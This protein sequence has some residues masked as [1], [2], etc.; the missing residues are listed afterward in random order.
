VVLDET[1][2]WVSGYRGLWGLSVRDPFEGEDAPAGPM[3]NR[4]GS[5]RLSWAHPVGFAELDAEPPPSQEASLIGANVEGASRNLS[6]LATRISDV[7]RRLAAGLV[8]RPGAESERAELAALR[9]EHE[10][11][12]LNVAELTRRLA[13]I[14][15]GED[16]LPPQAHLRRIAEPRRP[17]ADRAG[18]LLEAWAAVSIGLLLLALITALLLAPRFGILTA[19]A[20]IAFFV[21]VESVLRNR[22]VSLLTVIVRLMAILAATPGPEGA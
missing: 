9:M 2:A 20:V 16:L 4:D 5:V 18:I 14:R 13:A 21:F 6:A 19:V 3:F 11:L 12:V 17:G 1:Q 15:A 7:E 22:V 10:E 8:D